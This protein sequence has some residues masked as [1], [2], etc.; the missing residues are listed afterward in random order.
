MGTAGKSSANLAHTRAIRA[1]NKS[2]VIEL[3]TIAKVE[4]FLGTPGYLS[5]IVDSSSVTVE[6]R[7]AT[8]NACRQRTQVAHIRA[9]RASDKRMPICRIRFVVEFGI[10]CYLPRSA[11]A[12]RGT[13]RPTQRSEV[14]HAHSIRASDKRMLQAC[15]SVGISHYL[16]GI[17]D[18]GCVSISTQASQLDN[19]PALR[20]NQ[21]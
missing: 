15:G 18:I 2:S 20:I 5:C 12:Q 7:T 19:A 13:L 14:G 10:S 11:Y 4:E 17:V 6:L 21:P 16:P 9:V 3:E 1:G 8:I